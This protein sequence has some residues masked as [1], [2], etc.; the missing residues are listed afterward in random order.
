MGDDPD[1]YEREAAWKRLQTRQ[2]ELSRLLWYQTQ[3]DDEIKGVL[4]SMRSACESGNHAASGAYENKARHLQTKKALLPREI[5]DVEAA[6][7]QGFASIAK[8]QGARDGH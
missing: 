2:Q 1:E 4:A 5:Q 3:I 6:I 8:L 7:S